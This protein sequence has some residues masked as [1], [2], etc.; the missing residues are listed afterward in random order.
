MTLSTN[1]FLRNA[2]TETV[3]NSARLA[4]RHRQRF[5]ASRGDV[6]RDGKPDLVMSDLEAH[7]VTILL[8]Q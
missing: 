4:V 5:V 6:N 2:L 8:V 1:S 7:T 3:P